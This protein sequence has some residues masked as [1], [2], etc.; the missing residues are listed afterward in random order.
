MWKICKLTKILQL[1]KDWNLTKSY[2]FK[3]PL[4]ASWTT[5]KFYPSQSFS[6]AFL[7]LCK[8]WQLL[9]F[10]LNYTQSLQKI[11]KRLHKRWSFIKCRNS[12]L[13]YENV[14]EKL[15]DLWPGGFYCKNSSLSFIDLPSFSL[16]ILKGRKRFGIS[17]KAA[18][19]VLNWL[20]ALIIMNNNPQNLIS[21]SAFARFHKELFGSDV[22]AVE[23]DWNFPVVE[24]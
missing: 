22:A 6:E 19:V 16:R 7:K 17:D 4:G 3:S 2:F 23:D 9:Q 24:L 14:K 10:F 5:L 12:I 8:V 15:C 21:D 20:L 13:F 11:H 1:T 18:G